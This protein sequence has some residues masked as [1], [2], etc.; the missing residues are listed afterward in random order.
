MSEPTPEQI[1]EA[2]RLIAKSRYDA[3]MMEAELLAFTLLGIKHA[4]ELEGGFDTSIRIIDERIQAWWKCK[5][6][7][8]EIL[9]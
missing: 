3:V 7:E 9:T 8:T 2:C 6:R 1:Q 5:N 4:L